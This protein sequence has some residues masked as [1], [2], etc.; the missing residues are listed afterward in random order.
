MAHMAC[1]NQI[2][3]KTLG[4]RTGWDWVAYLPP[5]VPIWVHRHQEYHIL[6]PLQ[7]FTDLATDLQPAL[8]HRCCRGV[9]GVRC[10]YFLLFSTLV[11]ETETRNYPANLWVPKQKFFHLQVLHIRMNKVRKIC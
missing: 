1:A 11:I 2:V 10:A 3:V 4:G 8:V 6:V 7:G 5:D 9:L